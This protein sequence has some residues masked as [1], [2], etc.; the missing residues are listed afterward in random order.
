MQI[1]VQLVSPNVQIGLKALQNGHIL[2][3]FNETS[4]SKHECI[5]AISTNC[6]PSLTFVKLDAKILE[7]TDL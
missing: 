7:R 5:L 4:I 1:Q 2:A 6:M 3:K